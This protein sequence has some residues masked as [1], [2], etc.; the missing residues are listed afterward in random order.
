MGGKGDKLLPAHLSCSPTG[1]I[2]V[3]SGKLEQQRTFTDYSERLS[4]HRAF[5][6]YFGCSSFP[7]T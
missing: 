3:R 4:L 2:E 5:L 7:F 6:F 1:C